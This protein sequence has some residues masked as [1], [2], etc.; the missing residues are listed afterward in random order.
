[1]ELAIVLTVLIMI[2]AG[3]V[4]FAR[5]FW[6]YDA[7]AKATRDGARFMSLALKDTI[8]SSGVGTAQTLVVAA[9]NAANVK[10][11]ITTANVTVTCAPGA[12]TDGTSP[13]QVTVTISGF[14]VDIGGWFQFILGTPVYSGV[15]LA[16]S[17]TMRYMN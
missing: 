7:L 11:A 13:A 16:P 8:A 5:T 10:P 12:C 3:I 2:A 9:V 17:T 15:P 14:T 4:E 6:Y 1:M